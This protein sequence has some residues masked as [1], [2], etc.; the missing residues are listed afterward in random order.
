MKKAKL[1]LGARLP[2]G[3]RVGSCPLCGKPGTIEIGVYESGL[4]ISIDHAASH[5]EVMRRDPLNVR[6]AALLC[7]VR[8]VAIYM[9]V[10][11]GTLRAKPREAGWP[12]MFTVGDFGA[13]FNTPD[14]RRKEADLSETTTPTRA[15]QAARD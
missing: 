7:G 3:A 6:E 5:H 13:Y 10:Q 15:V 4:G 8:P 11:R 12:I 2:G 14:K 9:A 1:K